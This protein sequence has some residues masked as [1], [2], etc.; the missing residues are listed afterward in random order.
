[1]I[2]KY[3]L[4]FVGLLFISSLLIYLRRIASHLHSVPE[5]RHTDLKRTS[6]IQRHAN[7]FVIS[8]CN[9]ARYNFSI[10]NLERGFPNFFTFICHRYPFLND[11]RIH[12]SGA[13]V[14]KKISSNL[15][16]F[17][18][19]WTYKI[20][21]TSTFDNEWSFVFEDDV[22]IVEPSRWILQNRSLSLPNYTEIL[23]E[24]MHDSEVRNAH[25]FFY[26]GICGPQYKTT[27]RPIETFHNM[28]HHYRGHGMCAH[29]IAITKSRARTFWPTL[30]S[31]RPNGDYP[32]DVF[33]NAVSVRSGMDFYTL[34]A[35]IEMPPRTGHFGIVY[36]D[37][38]TFKT[39]VW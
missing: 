26:M 25:G 29:A 1:M 10:H 11:S 21:E 24:L 34:G 3:V 32:M 2:F 9:S 38:K 17:I 5:C 7:A 36:Q 27:K 28:I 18:D 14:D 33:I 30:S 31:F 37:R 35:N 23:S 20:P 15:I 12:T 13:M 4:T 16:A 8:E 6:D 22:N 19:V 39:T